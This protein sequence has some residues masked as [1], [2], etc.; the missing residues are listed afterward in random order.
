[1]ADVLCRVAMIRTA[2]LVGLTLAEIP[3]RPRSR[4]GR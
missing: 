1:M 4:A 3:Q 2:Q